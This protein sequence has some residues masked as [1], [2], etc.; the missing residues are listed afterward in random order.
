M[1]HHTATI[2][3]FLITLHSKTLTERLYKRENK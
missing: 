1:L 3:W 2:A